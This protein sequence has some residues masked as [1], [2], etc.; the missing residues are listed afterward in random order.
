[1]REILELQRKRLGETSRNYA[2]AQL[3]FGFDADEQ[4]QLQSNRRHWEKRLAAIDRELEAEPA[5]IRAVYEVKAQ[6]VEPI[7]LVYLWPV[8][9]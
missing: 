3:N 5:R 1:M 7:G 4:R 6:R 8:T 2:D 9:G